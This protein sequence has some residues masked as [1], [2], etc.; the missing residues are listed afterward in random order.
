MDEPSTGPAPTSCPL[1]GLSPAAY[2]RPGTRR[3]SREAAHPSF[4]AE[5]YDPRYIHRNHTIGWIPNGP[6]IGSCLTQQTA[7]NQL[8]V[9]HDTATIL[10]TI[11]IKTT[12]IITVLS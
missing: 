3:G 12:V 10:L 1:V 4:C 11:T 7:N 8:G 6:Q 9:L 2:L 5:D